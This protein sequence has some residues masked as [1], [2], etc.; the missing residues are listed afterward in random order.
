MVAKGE[1]ILVNE[2]GEEQPPP[3]AEAAP[4]A[5]GPESPPG[6]KGAPAAAGAGAA[7]SGVSLTAE[8]SGGLPACDL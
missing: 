2:A 8:D 3:Q 1:L 6:V 4:A 5:A 7:D